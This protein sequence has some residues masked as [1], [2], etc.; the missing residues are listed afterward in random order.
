IY[1]NGQVEGEET[2][3][4]GDGRPDVVVFYVDGQISEKREDLD[5][6]GKPDMVSRYKNGKLASREADSSEVFEQ[7]EKDGS[8]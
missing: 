4:N 1:S 6:D 5:F 8:K 2:D 7:W 3:R